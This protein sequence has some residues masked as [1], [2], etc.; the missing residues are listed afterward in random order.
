MRKLEKKARSDCNKLDFE[1]GIA[2]ANQI[3]MKKKALS[4]MM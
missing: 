1:T 4:Q 3:G 2:E